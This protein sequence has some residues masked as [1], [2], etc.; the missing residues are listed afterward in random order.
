M[1][2][3]CGRAERGTAACGGVDRCPGP[4]SY[5]ERDGAGEGNGEDDGAGM[6]SARAE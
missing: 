6:T 3:Q 5:G 1:W 4:I 2:Q